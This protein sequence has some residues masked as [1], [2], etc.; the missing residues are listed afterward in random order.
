MTP[1]QIITKLRNDAAAQP[2]SYGFVEDAH[3][4]QDVGSRYYG[5]LSYAGGY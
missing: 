3:R 4:V 5:Y 1:S 2:A